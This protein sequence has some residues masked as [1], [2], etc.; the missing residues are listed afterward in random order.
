MSFVIGQKYILKVDGVSHENSFFTKSSVPQGYHCGPLLYL[1]MSRDIVQCMVDTSA[2]TL[3][4]ADD[5]KL[6]RIG[7][8]INDQHQLQLAVDNLAT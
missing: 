2:F 4:Y 7:N 1:F 8:N 6:F 5:T 3:M